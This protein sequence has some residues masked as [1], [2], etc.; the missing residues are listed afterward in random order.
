M[1]ISV[2]ETALNAY[3]KLDEQLDGLLEPLVGKVIAIE[4]Q[5]FAETL[6][7]CPSAT[8]IQLLDAYNGVVDAKLSGSLTALGLMG[9]SATPMR[10]IFK[11]DVQ[12]S[13]DTLVAHKLQSVFNK[14]NINLEAKLAQFTGAKFAHDL[15]QILR[16]GR[17]WSEQSLTTLR[18]N[19]EEYLQEESR[20]LPAKPEADIFFTEVDVIRNDSE[21]IAQRIDRL[22][23]RL[24]QDQPHP[25]GLLK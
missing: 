11:G 1:V 23:T 12:I 16:S 4:I 7:I 24:M 13:G 9:L 22:Q 25:P 2:L 10:A 14:L 20:E 6:Y 3:L 21:R 19:I 15:S 8:Q 5:P 17:D 18:K